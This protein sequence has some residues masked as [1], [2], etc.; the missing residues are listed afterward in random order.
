MRL[1]PIFDASDLA[2]LPAV[3]PDRGF[4]AFEQRAVALLCIEAGGMAGWSAADRESF[5][6]EVEWLAL[7][8]HGKVD[9][10]RAQGTVLFFDD[11]GCCLQ[12]AL[13]LQRCVPELRLRLGMHHAEVGIASFHS[14]GDIL[15]CVVGEGAL[16]GARVAA[17]ACAGSV[18]ISPDAYAL[19]RGQV[20]E[21]RGCLLTEESDGGDWATASL[22]PAPSK[23]DVLAST[24]A[25]LGAA[26]AW[27][28]PTRL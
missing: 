7:R 14:N 13:N 5:A 28:M 3:E 22:T 21:A 12:M 4:I 25:G 2:K 24:F 23:D 15:W 9:R 1:Q 8:H 26:S 11:P 10:Y 16:E 18:V 17:T 19:V 20:R 6:A 27:V